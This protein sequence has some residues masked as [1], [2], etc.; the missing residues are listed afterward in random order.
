MTDT[1]HEKFIE[2]HPQLRLMSSADT[3][4]RTRTL[5]IFD[6]LEKVSV[7]FQCVDCEEWC[8]Y[9][10]ENHHCQRCVKYP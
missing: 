10:T 9:L 8:E 3:D 6:K 1:H 7:E 4:K 5:F 2:E